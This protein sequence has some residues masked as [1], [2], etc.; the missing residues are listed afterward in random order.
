MQ[1]PSVTSRVGRGVAVA[2]ALVLA[3]TVV[4]TASPGAAA[5]ET[6]T[7]A[8]AGATT[9]TAT[10]VRTTTSTT[11]PQHCCVAIG[12]WPTTGLRDGSVI[13]VRATAS[14]T[15]GMQWVRAQLCGPR[16]A[17][18]SLECAPAPLAP[19]TDYDVRAEAESAQVARLSFR[20]GVGTV[21]WHDDQGEPHMVS[22][23]PGTPCSL[24]VTTNSNWGTVGVT[25]VEALTFAAPRPVI[26]L[27]YIQLVCR[28]FAPGLACGLYDP[29]RPRITTT[30]ATTATA[31]P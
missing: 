16:R 14:G 1:M 20:V 3:V 15:A 9:T 24:F 13:Q 7:T 22:C 23:G 28:I 30:T 17:D 8:T 19:G 21:I 29:P 25:R 18:Y 2:L 12:V 5:D 10:T 27:W 4:G 26:P 31:G 11:Y 6:T